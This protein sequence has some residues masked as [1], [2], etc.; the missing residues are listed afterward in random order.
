MQN[1]TMLAANC[2]KT[3]NT[4]VF[5]RSILCMNMAWEAIELTLGDCLPLPVRGPRPYRFG[6]DNRGCSRTNAWWHSTFPRHRLPAFIS[7]GS[8]VNIATSARL[9]SASVDDRRGPSLWYAQA[10]AFSILISCLI[11]PL[12]TVMSFTILMRISAC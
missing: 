11:C 3:P 2:P 9:L 8:T 1:G 10:D 5:V 12:P 4:N 7:K 6:S